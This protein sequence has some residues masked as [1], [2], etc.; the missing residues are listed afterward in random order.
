LV[1]IGLPI[2]S[3]ERTGESG[4]KKILEIR[5]IVEPIQKVRFIWEMRVKSLSENRLGER[6]GPWRFSDRH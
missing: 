4:L 5:P 3:D 1:F 6:D 2:I